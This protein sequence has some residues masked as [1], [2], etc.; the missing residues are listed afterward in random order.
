MDVSDSNDK[1]SFKN[2][3]IIYNVAKNTIKNEGIKGLYRGFSVSIIGSIPA[4]AVYF[5][6]YE[7]FKKHTL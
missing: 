5:G 2:K 1:N 3:S 6:S 4:S 7:F